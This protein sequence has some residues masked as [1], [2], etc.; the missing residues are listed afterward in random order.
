MLHLGRRAGV[1]LLAMSC[2]IIA[3][4]EATEP[5]R[6]VLPSVVAAVTVYNDQAAVTRTGSVQVPAGDSILI[7]GGV[8]TGILQDG[9]NARGKAVG[10]VSIGSVEVR[11]ASFDPMEGDRRRAEIT[12]QIRALDDDIAA[13]DVRVASLTMRQHFISR[14]VEAAAAGGARPAP[15][16]GPPRPRLLDD[17]AAWPVATAT[18]ATEMYDAGE[19][20]RVASIAKRGLME[21]RQ[22]LEAQLS[23]TGRT[24]PGALEIAVSVNAEA[25]AAIDLAVT[26]QVRGAS[27]RP[28]YEARL[29]SASGRVGLRQEAVVV[30]RTG[31][32]W[33]DVTLTLSTSRPSAGVQPP[34][35]V[36]WRISLEQNYP[37]AA[38]ARAELR[39]SALMAPAPPPAPSATPA[40]AEPQP[41]EMETVAALALVAGLSVE[42]A[43]PS[44][45]S[46]RSD[47]A[48]RRVRIG[49]LVADGKLSVR[50]VPQSEPRGYLFAAFANPE[51]TP[52]LAGRASLYLDGVFVGRTQVPLVRPGEE[53]RMPFGPDERLKV[54]YEPQA[55]KRS[56]D[57]GL[58][59]GRRNIQ[60][61]VGLMIV[62]SFHDTPV[63]V[64]LVDQLPVSSDADLKV[65][66]TAD[67]KPMQRD[68]DDR[69]GVVSWTY[70]LKPGEERRVTFG[71]T[72]SAPTGKPIYGLPHGG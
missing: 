5:V 48:E 69:P 42:Y 38:S 64:T 41:A 27:W 60:S 46:V 72:V 66:E 30:Q 4:A 24:A 62:H 47:G 23:Q 49:D 25:P 37:V 40:D 56:S 32:D 13:V 18:V 16:D 7:L 45:S 39:A 6:I 19:A 51:K 57:W 3:P 71:Y 65:E 67:P 70:E 22:A 11:Q 29:D 26:Y 17:P 68:L 36:P 44:L 12:A 9:V 52:L 8:P 34:D 54:S 58:M 20:L 28:S 61:S 31:E 53:A 55:E 35:L 15:Q 1:A 63:T 43:I 33:T 50:T 14:I 2:V 10:K 21:R 59:Q